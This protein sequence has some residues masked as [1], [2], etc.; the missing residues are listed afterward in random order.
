MHDRENIIIDDTAK[1]M[2]ETLGHSNIFAA[3]SHTL[4]ASQTL[5]F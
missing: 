5:I 3:L 2:D 1:R 4:T